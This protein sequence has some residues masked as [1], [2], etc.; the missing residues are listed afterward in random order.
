[1]HANIHSKDEIYLKL[2]LVLNQYIFIIS[3]EVSMVTECVL[4]MDNV[5]VDPMCYFSECGVLCVCVV[6]NWVL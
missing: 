5:L 6:R 3:Y 2:L 1:M 4:R